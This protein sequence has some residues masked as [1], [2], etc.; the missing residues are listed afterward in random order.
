[1]IIHIYVPADL[2]ELAKSLLFLKKS[3]SLYPR[4]LCGKEI[5]GARRQPACTWPQL[6]IFTLD[7]A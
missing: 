7:E 1:L 4:E 3:H 5:V 2:L 6:A